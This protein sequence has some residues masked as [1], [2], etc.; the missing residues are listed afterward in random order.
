MFQ[1][2][3]HLGALNIVSIYRSWSGKAFSSI[4]PF[5]LCLVQLLPCLPWYY[6]Y[7]LHISPASCSTPKS[8]WLVP[9]R[10]VILQILLYTNANLLSG[11]GVRHRETNI[12]R[13]IRYC[14]FVPACLLSEQFTDVCAHKLYR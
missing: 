2:W 4:S 5:C 6:L 3:V 10:G 7:V 12:V 9:E 13:L 14:F 1:M 8:L 11:S